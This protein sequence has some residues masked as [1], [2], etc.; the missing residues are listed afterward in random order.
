MNKYRNELEIELAGEKYT[1]RLSIDG[2]VRIEEK[3]GRSIIELAQ[4]LSE[5]RMT[6]S[7]LIAVLYQGLKGG[8]NN[9]TEKEVMQLVS[10]T[11]LV[12]AM[13]VAGEVVVASLGVDDEEGKD[14]G[15]ENL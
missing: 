5:T 9:I 2:I 8:G 11:G 12:S 3:L 14:Q 10:T 1:A 13:A 4:R 15:T 6:T 7:E